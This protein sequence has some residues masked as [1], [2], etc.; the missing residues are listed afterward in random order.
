MYKYI[1][2]KSKLKSVYFLTS[3]GLLQSIELNLFNT[4]FLPFD[5]VEYS[6]LYKQLKF[7]LSVIVSLTVIFE[8]FPI[9]FFIVLLIIFF[10]L[11]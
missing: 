3:S 6:H 10:F 7:I 8:F 1:S 4:F 2:D 11:S 5:C 9:N